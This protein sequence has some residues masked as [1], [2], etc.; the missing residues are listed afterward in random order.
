MNTSSSDMKLSLHNIKKTKRPQFDFDLMNDKFPENVKFTKQS[1]LSVFMKFLGVWNN[2]QAIYTM[3]ISPVYN[4]IE[5]NLNK[6]E[7]II[8]ALEYIQNY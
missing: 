6:M 2:F 7:T 4:S 8:K 3:N 5:S 1:K